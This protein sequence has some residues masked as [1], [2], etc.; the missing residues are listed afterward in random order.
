MGAFEVTIKRW[1]RWQEILRAKNSN[2][3]WGQWIVENWISE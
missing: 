1:W 3:D 2:Y